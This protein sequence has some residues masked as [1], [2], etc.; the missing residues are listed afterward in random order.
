[1][2]RKTS[3]NHKCPNC[4]ANLTFNPKEQNWLCEYCDSEFKLEDLTKNEQ[5]YNEKQVEEDY[6]SSE[7]DVY[8][9]PDCGAEIITDLNTVATFCIYCKNTSI[10]KER[11][12]GKFELKHIIPFQNTKDDAVV[13]F[14]KLGKHHPLI[15]L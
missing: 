14:K 3:L 10:I 1:M 13:A 7:F 6:N 4:H 15:L 12:V 11:L 2:S 8:K 5:K 9:C